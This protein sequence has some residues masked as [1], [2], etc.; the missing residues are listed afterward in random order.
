MRIRRGQSDSATGLSR[1]DFLEVSGT[2]VAAVA[3]GGAGRPLAACGERGEGT[4]RWIQPARHA[5]RDGR[6]SLLGAEQD[7]LL[8]R[9]QDHARSRP[10]GRDREH[11]VR[12]AGPGGHGLSVARR[13]LAR[14]R[15]GH[16]ARSRSGKWAPSRCSTSPAEGR[17]AGRGQA[18][19]PARRSRSAAPD[20][21]RSSIRCWPRSAWRSTASSTSTPATSGP[22]R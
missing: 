4:V 16:P 7:R 18:S 8:R 5:R 14:H 22:S 21:R 10:D 13:V 11:E 1:R 3:L 17:E 15:S 9:H 6:L 19:S 20:G 2:G 12:R